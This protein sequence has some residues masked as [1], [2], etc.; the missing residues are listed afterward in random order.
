MCAAPEDGRRGDEFEAPAG[1]L[2]SLFPPLRP[3]RGSGSNRRALRRSRLVFRRRSVGRLRVRRPCML[4]EG[5]LFIV[6]CNVG[7]PSK[8]PEALCTTLCGLGT[9]A[10]RPH[11]PMP[12]QQAFGA[13]SIQFINEISDV[14]NVSIV[15]IES[16][17]DPACA[18]RARLDARSRSRVCPYILKC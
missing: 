1:E 8:L 7:N 2:L 13:C 10:H 17:I 12:S 3:R 18:D 9:P 16:G 15:D 14:R 4:H 11:D 5:L 6:H